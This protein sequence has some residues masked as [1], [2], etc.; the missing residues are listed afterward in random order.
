MSLPFTQ[1]QFF[2]VFRQY[3]DAVWPLQ[4][5]F[6]LFGIAAVALALSKPGRAGRASSLFLALLWSWTGIVYHLTYFAPIN[7]A[8]QAFGALFLAGAALFLWEGVIHGR[9]QF[10]APHGGRG[11]LAL[12]LAGYAL[13]IYPFIGLASGRHAVELATLGLPCP[14]TIFTVALIGLA[15]P[16]LPRSVVIAPL[17]WSLIGLSAAW[18]LGVYEDLGLLVAAVAAV[19]FAL[20]KPSPRFA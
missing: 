6:L 17:L 3:N 20:P 1:A 9:L 2:E 18:L 4:V 8:A 14:T 19:W 5:V 16:P 7:P 12:A 13:V 10:G 15:Q 11:A